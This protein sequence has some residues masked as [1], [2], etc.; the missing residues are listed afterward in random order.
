LSEGNKELILQSEL[1][2]TS[3]EILRLMEM[4]KEYT[5]SGSNGSS[6]VY[7]ILHSNSEQLL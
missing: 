4:L 3:E 2:S 6:L 5:T 7:D 1:A